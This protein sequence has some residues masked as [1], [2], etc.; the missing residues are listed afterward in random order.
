MIKPSPHIF[1]HYAAVG[2][3]VAN[4]VSGN[5]F[6]GDYDDS[7]RVGQTHTHTV[8]FTRIRTAIG[9]GVDVFQ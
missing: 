3:D 6:S 4:R 2:C 8:N 7:E 9:E 1:T 5:L